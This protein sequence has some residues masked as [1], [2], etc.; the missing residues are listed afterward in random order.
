MSHPSPVRV[1]SAPNLPAA[2]GGAI[3]WVCTKNPFYVVSA[4]LFLA[5]LIISFG[6]PAQAENTW[7]MMGGLAGYTLLLA[8]AACLLVR[9]ANVWDDVRTVLLLV[10]LMFL[11]T[12][13]TFDEVLVLD[14][15]RGNVCFLAGGVFAALVSEGVLRGIRLKLPMWFRGPYYLILALFFL[16]PLALRP[17]VPEPHSEALLW[18]L[19]GFSPLAGLVFLTLLPAIRRGPE[20]TRNNGSPWPWPLYPWSLFVFLAMAVIARS[21]LLCWSMHL[22]DNGDRDSVV[23]G[24]YFLVPFGLAVAV[25]LLEL[26]IS[27]QSRAA[28]GTALA[29]PLGLVLLALI[30]HRADPVYREFLDMF[31]ARLGGLPAFA[32]L[33]AAIVFYLYAA[34]RRIPWSIEALTAGLLALTF[35]GAQTLGWGD[36]VAAQPAPLLAAGAVQLAL[37]FRRRA[38]WRC[39][40]GGIA[41][42]AGL[43]LLGGADDV[44]LRGPIALHLVMLTMLLIGALFDDAFARWLR[45]AG[46]L[47]ALLTCQAALFLP[48]DLPASASPWMLTAYPLLMATLLAGYGIVLRFP[49]AIVSAGIVFASWLI[50]F[51]SQGYLALRQIVRGLDYLAWSL[52][53][54]VLA[55]AISLGKSGLLTRWLAGPQP[56]E[57]SAAK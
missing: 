23:F 1:S 36:W 11:A 5:G 33:W 56:K 46:C 39:L 6:D 30:G 3:R 51:A 50:V 29:L 35:V 20:Y 42:G 18:G 37:G 25:L 4:G 28:L 10:V 55:I 9:F 22:L 53:V 7:A 44:P 45:S 47:L 48:I 14:W 15:Q 40:L 43:S 21:F 52:A 17:M 13:V 31:A 2:A 26:G 24:P 27:S 8:G 49:F 57:S 16:Y 32:T 34:W 41:A 12:S 54:F 38:S 19:F